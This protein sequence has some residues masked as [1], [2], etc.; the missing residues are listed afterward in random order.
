MAQP[1][2]QPL[3]QASFPISDPSTGKPTQPFAQWLSGIDTA[4]RAVCA[5]ILGAPVQLTNAAS[6]DAAAAAG[7][8]VGQLYRSGSAVQ[9]RVK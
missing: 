7:V 2:N 4:V 6:D 3:Q 5:L 9:V 1:P 8:K